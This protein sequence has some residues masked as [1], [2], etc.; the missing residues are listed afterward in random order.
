MRPRSD[1]SAP[2][3][4]FS[5]RAWRFCLPAIIFV[6][7]IVVYWPALRAG[8]I[9]DDFFWFSYY[10]KSPAELLEKI[11]LQHRGEIEL[12]YFRPSLLA[13]LRLDYA[14]WGEDAVGFHLTSILLHSLNGLLLFYL[15]RVL[16]IDAL[17]SATASILFALYP[18]STDAVT[19]I[20]SRS[21]P[22][23]LAWL[24]VALLFWCAARL[25]ADGRWAALSVIA[26][27]VAVFAK[28]WA[29]AGILL[30]PIID[31][32]LRPRSPRMKSGIAPWHRIGYLAFLAVAVCVIAFRYWLFGDIG[33]HRGE[34]NVSSYFNLSLPSL[35]STVVLHDLKMF[36]TPVNRILWPEWPAGWRIAL[37]AAGLCSGLML[38]YSLGSAILTARRDRARFIYFAAA[39]LWIIVMFLPIATLRPVT[40]SLVRSRY[41]Y[42][43]SVGL[44]LWA[45]MSLG[46]FWRSGAFLRTVAVIIMLGLIAVSI[47]TIRRHNELWIESGRIAGQIHATMAAHTSD[48]TDGS[49]LFLVNFPWAY[50]DTPCAPAMY[51]NYIDFRYGI[52]GVGVYAVYKPPDEL[53]NWW[54]ELRS[55]WRIRSDGFFWDESTGGVRV[56]PPIAPTSSPAE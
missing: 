18:A 47:F 16:A 5:A 45:G 26:Y 11:M 56:L 1:A 50:R 49:S 10:I 2:S 8:F 14:L 22:L 46:L 29:V 42:A 35:W 27:I 13:S 33:G 28:E 30:L 21:D 24:L 4:L 54:E 39:I 36:F 48:L 37:V 17:S 51:G 52:K 9:S 53:D 25:R 23:A 31:W 15:A 44:A 55:R 7:P 3:R 40:D 41:L 19:W 12:E 34:A 38:L 20:A 32:L 43:A 6:V